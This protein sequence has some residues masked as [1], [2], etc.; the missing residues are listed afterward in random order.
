MVVVPLIVVVGVAVALATAL[1]FV[2]FGLFGVDILLGVAVELAFASAGGALAWRAQREGWLSHAMRRT[3]GPVAGALL[4]LAV[5]GA[6]LQHWV[7]GAGTWPQALRML[8]ASL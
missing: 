8:L 5:A 1:G 2:V 7:P 3:A 6:L 4:A